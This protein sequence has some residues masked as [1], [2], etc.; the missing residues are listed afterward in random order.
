MLPAYF[1]SPCTNQTIR[2]THH[3]IVP[4]SPL[5]NQPMPQHSTIYIPAFQHNDRSRAR[6]ATLETWWRQIPR[7]GKFKDN[8]CRANLVQIF[9]AEPCPAFQ[10]QNPGDMASVA[11]IWKTTTTLCF[12][13]GLITLRRKHR[14]RWLCS[15]LRLSQPSSQSRFQVTLNRSRRLSVSVE[16]YILDINTNTTT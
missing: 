13:H 6:F 3:D 9:P 8:R 15:W 12:R 11:V 5:W 14:V 10:E 2:C 16:P 1:A 7:L 4:F